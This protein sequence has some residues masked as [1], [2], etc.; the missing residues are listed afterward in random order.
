MTPGGNEYEQ[1]EH[2]SEVD[3]LLREDGRRQVHSR[4][5]FGH[6]RKCCPSCA[7]RFLECAVSWRDHRHSVLRGPLYA[8][9]ER[10][11]ATHLCSLVQED[12]RRARFRGR[13]EDTAG[14]VS[15]GDRAYTC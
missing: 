11:Y 6:S 10:A 8:V 12:L 9:E 7:G 15:R 13:H 4:E 3:L 1:H 2:L 14:V 5:R